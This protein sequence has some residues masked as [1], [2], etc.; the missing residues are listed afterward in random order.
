MR[1]N[2]GSLY[3]RPANFLQTM[4]N[5]KYGCWQKQ[6]ARRWAGLSVDSGE[7]VFGGGH[8]V[9]SAK[10]YGKRSSRQKKARSMVARRRAETRSPAQT[11]L[12]VTGNTKAL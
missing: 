8:C 11:H 6:E 9:V 3:V 12:S 1:M 5:K 4:W 10:G 7:G 2:G